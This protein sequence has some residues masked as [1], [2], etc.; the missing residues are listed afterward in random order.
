MRLLN[1][2]PAL[3]AGAYALPAVPVDVIERHSNPTP[4]CF[5]FGSAGFLPNDFIP[6]RI[7]REEWWCPQ[8]MTYGF[9]GFSYPME[10]GCEDESYEKINRDFGMMRRDFG[11]TMARVY[12]PQCYTTEIWENLIR[13]GVNNNMAIVIQV[14]WPL[15]GDALD[16]WQLTQ[17]SILKVLKSGPYAK[18]APY[19]FH[20][21]E[22]GTE[23]IGDS[24]D[25]LD[26]GSDHSPFIVALASFR[27]ALRPYGIPVGISEDWDRPNLMSGP[28]GV[29]L[30]PVGKQIYENSDLVHAHIMPYYHN[31]MT[32]SQAWPYIQQ[33]V[34]WYKENIKLPTIISETQWA[35]DFNILHQGGS[36]LGF[37]KCDC[38]PEQYNHFWKTY[39]ENCHY[40]KENNIGWFLHA[41]LQEGTFDMLMPNGSYAI[42]NWRPQRC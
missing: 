12:L 17:A 39:D 11:A 36:D 20:S 40:F 34:A 26:D 15:N 25:S 23:P 6:P 32:E 41:W 31:N 38:G 1:T 2:L 14:A 24:D 9:L 21:A 35:W 16:N 28:N 29:G 37:A 8:S 13:A 18:V 3:V 4:H 7:S 19:V 22:F 30:G 42:K 27:A 33:Q 5:P 10:Y